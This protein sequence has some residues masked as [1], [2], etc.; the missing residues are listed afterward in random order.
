MRDQGNPAAHK[1]S[2]VIIPQQLP[3]PS[4]SI[5]IAAVSLVSITDNHSMLVQIQSTGGCTFTVK[6]GEPIV[7][8]P[9]QP[10][11]QLAQF[12]SAGVSSLAD[13]QE[14]L[15]KAIQQAR[16]TPV[17]PPPPPPPREPTPPSPREH[18]PSPSTTVTGQHAE[19]L[20][21]FIAIQATFLQFLPLLQTYVKILMTMFPLFRLYIGEG[22]H[23]QVQEYAKARGPKRKIEKR[24]VY[25]AWQKAGGPLMHNEIAKLYLSPMQL[26]NFESLEKCSDIR[27]LLTIIA[28]NEENDKSKVCKYAHRLKEIGNDLAH[29]QS[30]K[31]TKEYSQDALVLCPN[32]TLFRVVTHC[33]SA[34]TVILYFRNVKGWDSSCMVK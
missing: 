16:S 24:D 6:D 34:T 8:W 18:S 4:N 17:A 31:F 14:L 13:K 32:I 1:V 5:Q 22:K 21:N 11:T 30:D 9:D 26:K 19:T 33:F 10:D 3:P 15:N 29:T 20:Q 12:F 2:L 27:V 28:A 25:Q 23:G 7:Q